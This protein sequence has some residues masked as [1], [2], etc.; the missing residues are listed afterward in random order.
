MFSV[1]KVGCLH[2]GGLAHNSVILHVQ[3]E[4]DWQSPEKYIGGGV[5]R[6]YTLLVLESHVLEAELD[7]P[8]VRV[9]IGVLA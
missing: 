4:V 2:D 3:E 8:P 5:L 7:H 1:S 9:H 6:D